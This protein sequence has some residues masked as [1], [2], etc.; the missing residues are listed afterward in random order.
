ME[1]PALPRRC[2]AELIGT[3]ILIVCGCGAVVV[4]DAT[5]AVTHPGVAL[6]W[7]LVVLALIYALGDVSGCH[8]NPAVTLGFAAAGRFPWKEVGPYLVAQVVGAVVAACFLKMVFPASSTLGATQPAGDVW[9][10]FALELFLTWFLMLAVLAVST[11]AKE[12][13]ITAGIAVGAIIGLEAMFAG[14]ICGASMNPARSLAPAVVSGRV[15]HLWIYLLAPT[16]GALLAVPTD[17]IWRTARR[18]SAGPNHH[19]RADAAPLARR[20]SP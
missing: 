14:P 11:G 1:P 10:S 3:F 18:E 12:K 20:N 5:H 2:A 8:I 17:A 16:A 6:T 9:Q 15:E 19:R 4:N 7:G 13:G